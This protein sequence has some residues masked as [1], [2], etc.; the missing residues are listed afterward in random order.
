MIDV[1][2][3][4]ETCRKCRYRDVGVLNEPCRTGI[5]LIHYS[6]RCAAFKPSLW[7]ILK[8]LIM[9]VRGGQD[10]TN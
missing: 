9:K 2:K 1:E 5:Y 7:T 6:G 10:E 4:T 8:K 3:V